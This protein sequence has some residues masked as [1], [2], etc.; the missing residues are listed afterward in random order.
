[1]FKARRRQITV[2]RGRNRVKRTR[3]LAGIEIYATVR[4]NRRKRLLISC[5]PTNTVYAQVYSDTFYYK[6]NVLYVKP[7]LHQ[8]HVARIQVSRTS[9]LYQDTSGYMSP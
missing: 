8:I 4:V 5:S 1:M 9:N 2:E 3:S 6:H 7:R